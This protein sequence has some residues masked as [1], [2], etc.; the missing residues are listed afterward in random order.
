MSPRIKTLKAIRAKLRPEP[1]REPL[2][3][4]PKQ[5]APPRAT[6]RQRRRAGRGATTAVPEHHG[7][8]EPSSRSGI[9]APPTQT[10]REYIAQR[11]CLTLYILMACCR[12]CQSY[13]P[14]N[15]KGY[16]TLGYNTPK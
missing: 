4:P 2:P 9:Q 16:L 13:R 12:K 7:N 8:H 10:E 15:S 14:Q 3:P 6:A 5:Y 1:V 11:R